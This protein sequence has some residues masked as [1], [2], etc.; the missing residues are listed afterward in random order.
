MQ[1]GVGSHS[2]RGF[3]RDLNGDAYKYRHGGSCSGGIPGNNEI[4]EY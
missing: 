3:A 1:R 2:R 4:S